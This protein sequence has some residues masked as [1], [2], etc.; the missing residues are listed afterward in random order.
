MGACMHKMST[1]EGRLVITPAELAHLDNQ[2]KEKW[3]QEGKFSIT[4]TNIIFINNRREEWQWSLKHLKCYSFEGKVFS[5]E[6]CG[7]VTGNYTVTCKDAQKIFDT[8]ARNI[9]QGMHQ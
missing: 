8:V 7:F 6:G 2:K 5:F 1:Q 4:P 9:S 3:R